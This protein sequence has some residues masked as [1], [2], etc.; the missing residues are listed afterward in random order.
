[1]LLILPVR[2]DESLIDEA[3]Q[4]HR[5]PWRALSPSSRASRPALRSHSEGAAI[6]ALTASPRPTSVMPHVEH[7]VANAH[8]LGSSLLYT[9]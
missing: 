2:I 6:E 8:D 9:T 4:A 7:H 1:V 3:A 5:A